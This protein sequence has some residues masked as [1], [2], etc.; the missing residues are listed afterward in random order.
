MLKLHENEQKQGDVST[1]VYFCPIQRTKDGDK[2]ICNAT[3]AWYDMNQIEG[4]NCAV[5]SISESLQEL[6]QTLEN[7]RVERG[8]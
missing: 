5:F 6:G 2:M 3:C 1:G 7:M 4:C 8:A